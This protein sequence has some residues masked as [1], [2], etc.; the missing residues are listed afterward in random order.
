MHDV[1]VFETHAN[2]LVNRLRPLVDAGEAVDMQDMFGRAAMD[3]ACEYVIGLPLDNVG[4]LLPVAGQAILGPK[5][6]LNPNATSAGIPGFTEALEAG[7]VNITRRR[8][9]GDLV[10]RAREFFKDSQTENIK[11][12]RGWLDPIVDEAFA[13]RGRSSNGLTKGGK[14]LSETF[15]QHAVEIIEGELIVARN[16]QC[17]DDLSHRT[18]DRELARVAVLNV[19]VAARDTVHACPLDELQH[20]ADVSCHSDDCAHDIYVIRTRKVSLGL[21]S[22]EG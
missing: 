10:W 4:G 19:V 16:G 22:L 20:L 14:E 11:V 15:L 12:V 2:K 1:A 8:A 21:R 7:L 9:Q 13:A 18:T 3:L 5:G 17:I 6:S